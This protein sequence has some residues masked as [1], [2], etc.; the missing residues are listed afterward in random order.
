MIMGVCLTQ[1]E[2]ALAYYTKTIPL[3][4]VVPIYFLYFPSYTFHLLKLLDLTK[5]K[6]N[7]LALSTILHGQH[8][9]DHSFSRVQIC[10]RE[11]YKNNEMIKIKKVMYH[12]SIANDVQFT[13]QQNYFFKIKWVNRI[14][15]SKKVFNLIK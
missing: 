7:K 10:R 1:I 8:K 4:N 14:K 12:G 11:R 2:W 5:N 15:F 3:D 6:K 13:E 9:L